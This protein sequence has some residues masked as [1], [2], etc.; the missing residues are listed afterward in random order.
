MDQ[1]VLCSLLYALWWSSA[2]ALGTLII[3]QH[4]LMDCLE[5]FQ[6]RIF[7]LFKK[8]PALSS[9][10]ESECQQNQLAGF[11]VRLH[12]QRC[13]Q[14]LLPNSLLWS[15]TRLFDEQIVADVGVYR[16]T[17]LSRL[18]C[19]PGSPRC[20]CF[21]VRAKTMCLHTVDGSPHMLLT[22]PMIQW[23]STP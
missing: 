7:S 14:N 10:H 23:S 4:K 20:F 5:V 13:A 12:R 6:G 9:L 2:W 3:F 16:G 1:L 15:E 18:F 11:V 19:K 21:L 22:F 17:A 8:A